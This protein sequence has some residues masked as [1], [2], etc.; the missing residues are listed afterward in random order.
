MVDIDE[1]IDKLVKAKSGKPGEAVDLSEEDVKYVCTQAREV[2]MQQPMLLKVDSPIRI[3]G[4]L[5]GQFYDL[6]RLFD[7]GG[8]PPEVRDFFD[9]VADH[10][11]TT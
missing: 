3:C 6:L 4:D 2:F 8:Y 7:S 1:I 9:F 5:H 11:D 10:D